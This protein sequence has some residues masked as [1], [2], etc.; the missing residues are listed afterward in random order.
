LDESTRT[1]VTPDGWKLCLRDKDKNELY[2]LNHDADE[3]RN[4]FYDGSHGDVIDELTAQIHHWQ[5][6]TG[7]TLKV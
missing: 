7:D 3:R 2:D 6:G 4:L 1:V 5:Q